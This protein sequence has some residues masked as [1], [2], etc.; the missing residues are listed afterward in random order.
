MDDSK[1]EIRFL[2][3]M[4]KLHLEPGDML[5]LQLDTR[6]SNEQFDRLNEQMAEIFGKR[7][8]IILDAGMKLG[9]VTPPR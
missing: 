1:S 4:T 6:I 2:G 8:V 5:V 3:D 9:A 7:R